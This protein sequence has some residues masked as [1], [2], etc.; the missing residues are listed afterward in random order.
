MCV[1]LV[2]TH[3]VNEKS[4]QVNKSTKEEQEVETKET[5]QG[6][7]KSGRDTLLL[8]TIDA[9]GGM[10]HGQAP[11]APSLL[12]IRPHKPTSM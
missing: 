5:E 7:R 6:P 12:R 4:Q 2:D 9:R 11:P 10:S 3:V 1:L 8:S